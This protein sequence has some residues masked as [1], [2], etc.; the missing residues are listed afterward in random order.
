MSRPFS[1]RPALLVLPVFLLTGQPVFAASECKGLDPDA[2]AA[3]PNCRWMEGYTRKDGVQV[4]SHCRLAKPRKQDTTA[5][6]ATNA[7]PT[8]VNA[9]TKP[10]A[11]TTDVKPATTQAETKPEAATH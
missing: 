2:C 9:D 6:S 11:A 7:T 8:T 10:E 1:L 4:S 3:N 5:P